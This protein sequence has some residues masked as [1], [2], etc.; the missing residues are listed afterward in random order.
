M[1]LHL[2]VSAEHRLMTDRETD[3]DRIYCTCIASLG[4][5]A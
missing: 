3:D 4:K 5:N 1:I 2:V